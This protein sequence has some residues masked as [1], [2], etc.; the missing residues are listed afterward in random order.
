MTRLRVSHISIYV[1]RHTLS[2]SS[3]PFQITLA[4]L[5][6]VFSAKADAKIQPISKLQKYFFKKVFAIGV[7]ALNDSVLRQEKF[8]HTAGK[9]RRK[10]VLN[11]REKKKNWRSGSEN[12]ENGVKNDII[13]CFIT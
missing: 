8:Y 9:R 1:C 5:T 11:G 6:A 13:V 10:T 12:G 7:L 2:L 4:F 3:H